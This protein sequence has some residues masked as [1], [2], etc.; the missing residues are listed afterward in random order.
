LRSQPA[1]PLHVV[2]LGSERRVELV[3]QDSSFAEKQQSHPARLLVIRSEREARDR[4]DARFLAIAAGS[5]A[6]RSAQ[7]NHEGESQAA[8]L[9]D[10]AALRSG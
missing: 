10:L 9:A 6:K 3:P 2:H 8:E 5:R 4:E 1:P 7:E